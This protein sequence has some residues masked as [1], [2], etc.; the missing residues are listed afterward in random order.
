MENTITGT[1]IGFGPEKSGTSTNGSWKFTQAI[2]KTGTV[3]YPTK[4]A[5]EIW[6]KDGIY[7][8]VKAMPIGTEI[9]FHVN[10]ESKEYQDKWF[11]NAKA[12]KIKE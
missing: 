3:K 1:L 4:A 5:V 10:I 8:K 7:D 2:L 12:W 11:T 9:T 6:D